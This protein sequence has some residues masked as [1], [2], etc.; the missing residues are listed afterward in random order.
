VKSIADIDGATTEEIE[1][2]LADVGAEDFRKQLAETIAEPRSIRAWLAGMAMQGFVT[3]NGTDTPDATI[4]RW[5]CS[6]A[7][8]VIATLDGKETP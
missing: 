2:F 7:D 1:S 5:S 8:A 4:A 6:L 3:N